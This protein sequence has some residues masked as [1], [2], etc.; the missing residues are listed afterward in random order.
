M[1]QRRRITAPTALRSV[2]PTLAILVVA[3]LVVTAAFG[4]GQVINV[5][6]DGRDPVPVT[7]IS[8]NF[9]DGENVVVEDAAIASQGGVPGPK[10]VK[11]FHSE[12]EFSMFALTWEEEGQFAAFVRAEDSEGHWGP[13]YSAPP[14]DEIPEGGKFGTELI[15]IEPTNRV[16]VSVAGVDLNLDDESST[17][18]DEASLGVV[19]D[20]E[21]APAAPGHADNQEIYP[22]ETEE[23]E[24]VAPINDSYGDIQPV[25]D[26]EEIVENEGPISAESIEAVFIDGNASAEDEQ[27][28]LDID[29]VVD[30]SNTNGMPR[31]VTRSGWGAN[32][33]L[34]R[35][36]TFTEPTSAIT[37]HH[38]AGS[39][40]YSQAQSP[41][42][43]RGIQTYHGANLG[44]QDIGYNA[45]VDKYGTL[46]EGRAGGLDRG[47]Q[48]AHVG[49]FNQ[50]TWA[51]S[52]M[53][54]YQT[55]QPS[56]AMLNAMA[57][58][59]GW[60]AAVS[61]FD[62]TG[63][64][65]HY[66]EA[67]FSG[68]KYSRGQGATFNNINSH[69]DFHYNEC[70][71]TNLYNRLGDVRQ[72]AKQK[73]DSI[74]RGGGAATSSSSSSSSSAAAAPT[75]SQAPAAQEPT[76]RPV[77]IT[78]APA[79]GTPTDLIRRILDGDV[80][81]ILAALGTVTVAILTQ[82]SLGD[83][84]SSKAAQLGD[85]ELMPGLKVSQLTPVVDAAVALSSNDEIFNTWK[86]VKSQLGLPTTA[87]QNAGV[88]EGSQ[89]AEFALFEN[90]IVV[91]SERTGTHALWGGIFEA[92]KNSGFDLGPLGLPLTEEYADENGLIKVDFEG[93]SISY[94][95]QTHVIDINF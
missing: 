23:S 95:P 10:T 65:Y 78:T 89:G 36:P 24:G 81:A 86:A 41:G 54:N 93:G 26:T 94:N 40:N 47:V 32:P 19:P 7:N 75:T 60:R 85:H 72:R 67:N 90:G 61:G 43:V 91:S 18:A 44:W 16:Q 1:Q 35:R 13:W 25:V 55:A 45:L 12:E 69:R 28:V 63:T 48:G 9:A 3:T 80:Q 74:N 49:G 30:A 14:I 4:V 21:V 17:D 64:S 38:T 51:I 76:Q 2:N 57:D 59:A 5:Q 68:S 87:V 70:P 53:G 82:T 92:W 88:G 31:V 11:E 77:E 8:S 66:A 27:A 79:Q 52:A 50:N 34:S 42:I 6:T 29:N 39:N 46:Y 58:L 20:F 22:E 15:Y 83:Q 73:Y 62:P 37:I 84:L 33:N 56:E 71:G